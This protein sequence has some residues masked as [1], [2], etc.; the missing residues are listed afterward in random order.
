[1]KK[2]ELHVHA[3]SKT[4]K[5]II[6]LLSEIKEA[7]QRGSVSS[8]GHDDAEDWSFVFEINEAEE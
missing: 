6:S 7:V 1:M 4:K 3:L 5:G 8:Q 2:F